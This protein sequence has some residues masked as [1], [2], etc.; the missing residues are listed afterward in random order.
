MKEVKGESKWS[1]TFQWWDTHPPG[2]V[3]VLDNSEYKYESTYTHM[4]N[5]I[6]DKKWYRDNKKWVSP[7]GTRSFFKI[8]DA[9]NYQRIFIEQLSEHQ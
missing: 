8:L 1:G 3:K 4:F 9:Y 7:D 5:Y 6:R 2:E